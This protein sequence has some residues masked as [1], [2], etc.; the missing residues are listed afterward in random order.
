MVA[1]AAVLG[2]GVAFLTPAIFAAI[3]SI[4]PAHER[5]G[6][7]GT[8]TIFIDLGIGGGPLLLGLIAASAGIPLAFVS[9]AAISAAAAP[10]LLASAGRSAR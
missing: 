6:A 5:G 8:A 1:G 2:L 4:V 10:V 3:F 9:A 7:A